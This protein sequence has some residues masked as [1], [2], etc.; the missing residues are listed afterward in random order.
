M[1]PQMPTSQRP[2]QW[3][4]PPENRFFA[5]IRSWKWTRSWPRWIGGVCSG[6]SARTGWDVA[7]VRGVTVILSLFFWFPVLLYGVAWLLLPDRV[8]GR[9][10]LED[11]IVG[12]FSW[13]Q[14][15]ALAFIIVGVFNPVAYMAFFGAPWYWFLGLLAFV[16]CAVLLLWGAYPSTSFRYP[17]ASG[18][19]NNPRPMPQAESV[20]MANQFPNLTPPPAGPAGNYRP[21]TYGPYQYSPPTPTVI[22]TPPKTL[23]NRVSAL[24]VGVLFLIAAMMVAAM[25]V[26]NHNGNEIAG[27]RLLI[28]LCCIVLLTLGITLGVA[29]LQ[30][31]RGGWLTGV[32][33]VAAIFLLPAGLG[34]ANYAELHPV[35]NTEVTPW[36]EIT[37]CGDHCFSV[38][39][40]ELTSDYRTQELWVESGT[41]V[42]DLTGAPADFSS[43]IVV[44]AVGSEVE[45]RVTPDQAW[46]LDLDL[47]DSSF[48]P[49]DG[50]FP[51]WLTEFFSDTNVDWSA[52]SLT[53]TEGQGIAVALTG[54]ASTVTVVIDED[55]PGA[56]PPQGAQ[57]TDQPQ[58]GDQPQ[59]DGQE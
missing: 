45:I 30:G 54:S 31:R 2:P 17:W 13:G 5:A 41:V 46:A 59:S 58:S 16:G 44:N 28:A 43:Q 25:Q 3:N 39:G 51:T 56:T 49:G 15:G 22:F 47:T 50:P 24:V 7:L 29:A 38:V 6:I 8:S 33:V 55:A 10:E 9:I 40:T 4:P 32:S 18:A 57:S 14:V 26:L 53:F 20:P 35:T 36:S 1:N 48:G 37:P 21:G 12:R 27:R 52:Q 11:A 34:A 23:S 42:L 19:Q